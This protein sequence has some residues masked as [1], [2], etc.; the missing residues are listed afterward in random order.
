MVGLKKKEGRGRLGLSLPPWAGP[1]AARSS[2]SITLPLKHQHNGV[3]LIDSL[4][5]HN[6]QAR[7]LK[8]LAY[9]NYMGSEHNLH[10]CNTNHRPFILNDL[11]LLKPRA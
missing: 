10:K 7:A 9:M 11:F 8:C 6:S 3:A 5:L 2:Q 4:F 1:L